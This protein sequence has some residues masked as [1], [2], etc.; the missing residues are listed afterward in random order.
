MPRQTGIKAQN[1]AVEIMKK[2]KVNPEFFKRHLFVTL[3]MAGLG[4]WFGYDGFVKYPA[5]G[6][7]FFAE[8]HLVREK[9]TERQKQFMILSF[10]ASILVGGHLWK[11]ASFKVDYD[12]EGFVYKGERRLYRDV[13]NVDR[14]QWKKKGIVKADGIVFDAWHHLGVNEIEQRLPQI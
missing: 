2:L 3:L 9:A 4:C 13:K 10:I 7:E 11:I 14:S 6:D 12:D 1:K 8:R 5:A